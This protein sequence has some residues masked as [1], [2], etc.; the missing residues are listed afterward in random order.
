LFDALFANKLHYFSQWNTHYSL[1]TKRYIDQGQ[2]KPKPL[3]TLRFVLSYPIPRVIYPGKPEVIGATLV[4]DVVGYIGTNWGLG[5]AGHGAYEGGVP[6]LVLYALILAFGLRVID[7]PMRDQPANPFLLAA[8]VSASPHIITIARGDLGI[9]LNE[10]IEAYAFMVA[11]AIACRF[12]FGTETTAT[13][14]MS[15][16]TLPNIRPT[17]SHFPHGSR[18]AP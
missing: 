9:M 3:N 11:L 13:S 17:F 8:F 6:A 1:L 2:L 14:G 15:A 5:I 12:I 16:W 18:H 10:I 7:D 4:R